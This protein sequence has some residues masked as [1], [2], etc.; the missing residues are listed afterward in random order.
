MG[1][2][3]NKNIKERRAD[4]RYHRSDSISVKIVFSSENPGLL[5]KTL[6]GST[7]DVSASG[8]RIEVTRP[9]VL[10]SVLD[11]WVNL[12]EENRKYFLTGNIRWCTETD[13]PGVYQAGLVLR[14]RSDTVTDLASWRD[15]FKQGFFS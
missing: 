4:A 3:S 6:D 13:K 1:A 14:E 2:I 5:G 7:L 12:E 8:M 10:D 15:L 9:I 11:I